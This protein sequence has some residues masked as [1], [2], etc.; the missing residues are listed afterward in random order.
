VV[1]SHDR[2]F[3]DR[4]AT[5]ILAFE[6][7]SQVVWYEGNYQD[8]EEDRKR[9]LGPEALQPHRI[10]VPEAGAL[11][12]CAGRRAEP[13]SGLRASEPPRLAVQH[14]QEGPPGPE[15][16]AGRDLEV[17]PLAAIEQPLEGEGH[18]VPAGSK[19][20]RARVVPVAPPPSPAA[21]AAPTMAT[22]GK[23]TA[24]ATPSPCPATQPEPEP[25]AESVLGADVRQVGHQRDQHPP[26]L[27]GH[28]GHFEALP[29]ASS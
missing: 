24:R 8:Y 12:G 4:V 25:P 2:W 14:P 3:L 1:I 27:E 17:A 26:F 13:R 18:P 21:S 22:G 20:R 29:R 6:G 10:K 19:V 15:D 5:H 16:A 23:A 9:R 7:D 28:D 11:R